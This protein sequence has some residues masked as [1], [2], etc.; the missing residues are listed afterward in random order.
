MAETK[1]LP[2]VAEELDLPS[3]TIKTWLHQLDFIPAEKDG[4]GR[5]RFGPEA[6]GVLRQIQALRLDGRSLNTVRHR[7][8]ARSTDDER[9]EE[10]VAEDQDE[11]RDGRRSAIDERALAEVVT[12]AVTDAV[13]GQ[14]ELAERYARAAHQ[15]GLLEERVRSVE[16]DRDRLAGEHGRERECHAAEL[17]ELKARLQLLEAPKEEPRQRPWW[18]PW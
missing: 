14:V 7:L 4:A 17:T 6:E 9:K 12:R 3:N 18:R 2:Q 10:H 11:E 16:A 13:H 1:T 8:G 15:I 5:W